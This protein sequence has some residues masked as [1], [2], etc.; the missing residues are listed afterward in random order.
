VGSGLATLTL[1]SGVLAPDASAQA[2]NNLLGMVAVVAAARL[3]GLRLMELW[4]GGRGLACVFRYQVLPLPRMSSSSE[5]GVVAARITW[6]ATWDVKLEP[7]VVEAWEAVVRGH[8][9]AGGLQVVKEL[10]GGGV[11]DSIKSHGDAICHL[12]FSHDVCHPVSLSQIRRG[13]VGD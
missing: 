9:L 7:V 3:P 2:I 10:L 4:N 13:I 1:T 5:E 11:A 12:G 8:G 6:R